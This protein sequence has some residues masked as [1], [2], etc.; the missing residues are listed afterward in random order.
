M[1]VIQKALF[2]RIH[3]SLAASCIV[4][5]RLEFTNDELAVTFHYGQAGFSP[6]G[7]TRTCRRRAGQ[8]RAQEDR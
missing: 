3:S 7:C 8:G 2:S 4:P 1:Q 5:K 6:M